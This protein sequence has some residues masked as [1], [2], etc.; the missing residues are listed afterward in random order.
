MTMCPVCGGDVSSDAA[1]CPHCGFRLSGTTQQFRPIQLDAIDV[2]TPQGPRKASLFVLRGP[3]SGLRF[4]LRTE[5]MTVGRDPEC[6][7]FLNDMTVS[8]V[9]AEILPVA[10]GFVICDQ[11]SFNGV[12]VNNA[13]VDSRRLHPNDIVQIGSFLL[14]YEEE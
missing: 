3:Q 8:R 6:D 2:P 9:H 13:T 12:W 7:I 1:A 5:R 11:N 4:L 14:M 10:G